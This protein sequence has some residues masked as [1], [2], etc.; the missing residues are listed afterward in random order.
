MINTI[1]AF[2]MAWADF[3]LAPNDFTGQSLAILEGIITRG[4][5]GP[6]YGHPK[7]SDDLYNRP[8]S[9][10]WAASILAP[11]PLTRRS[12]HQGCCRLDSGGR[13]QAGDRDVSRHDPVR[14]F[15]CGVY[16]FD[17]TQRRAKK[18]PQAAQ[19]GERQQDRQIGVIGAGLMASRCPAVRTAY[20]CPVLIKDIKQSSWIKALPIAAISLQRQIQEGKLSRP[21]PNGSAKSSSPAP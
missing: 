9:R 10:S 1:K 8:S 5:G 2:E 21:T 11:S 14:P 20:Q 12:T 13:L 18:L 17:L 4:E 15:K 16:S 3:L 6:P 7:M 19:R